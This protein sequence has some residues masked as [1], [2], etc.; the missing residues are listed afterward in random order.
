MKYFKTRTKLYKTT[1]FSTFFIFDIKLC[2]MSSA[3]GVP[4]LSALAVFGLFYV[5]VQHMNSDK[6]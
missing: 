2:Q 4:L 6:Q 3:I 1:I 5:T